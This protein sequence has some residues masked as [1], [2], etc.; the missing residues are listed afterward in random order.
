MLF[1]RW[2]LWNHLDAPLERLRDFA[3][4]LNLDVTALEELRREWS[5]A[6]PCEGR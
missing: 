6:E 2:G 1:R 3:R 4:D 5:Y